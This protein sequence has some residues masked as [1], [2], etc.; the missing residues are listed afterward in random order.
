MRKLYA[1]PDVKVLETPVLVYMVK[2]LDLSE[3]N[4][5]WLKPEKDSVVGRQTTCAP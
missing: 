2:D 4:L 3:G 5:T 1:G